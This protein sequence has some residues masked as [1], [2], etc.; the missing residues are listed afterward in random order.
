MDMELPPV[1]QSV[2]ASRLDEIKSAKGSS[3]STNLDSEDTVKLSP[4]SLMVSR[5]LDQVN[6]MP[7]SR[8]Q[9]VSELQAQIG[10]GNYPPPM[11]VDGLTNLIGG[12][13]SLQSKS[14]NASHEE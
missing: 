2:R 7:E 13:L 14:A 1:G 10:S 5:L 3:A 9:V 11:L 12:A 8:P 6:A 4:N